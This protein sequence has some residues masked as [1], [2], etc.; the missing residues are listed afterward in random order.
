MILAP[1]R[2]SDDAVTGLARSF[3]MID[4]IAAQICTREPWLAEEMS[5]EQALELAVERVVHA[6]TPAERRLLAG[7]LESLS[8]ALHNHRL[9]AGQ[10]PGA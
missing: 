5:L 9:V 6:M 2:S 7:T 1:S 10:N 3:E 8:R 4:Q